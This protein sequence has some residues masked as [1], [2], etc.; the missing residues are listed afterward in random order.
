MSATRRSILAGSAAL[1]L[2]R[3]PARAQP[4][5]STLRYG[6]S[7]YPP[8]LQPWE[9]T[10]ASAGT[11]KLLIGRS[12][13]SYDRTGTLQ[14]ELATS[15]SLDDDGAWVF[16][17]RRDARFHNG[18]PVT[19]EDVRWTVEQVAAGRSTAYMRAQFQA[20]GRVETPDPYTVRLVT[21]ERL[22]TV[23]SWFANYNMAICWHGS[24]PKALV[25]CGPFRLAG[26]ERGTSVTVQASGQY[27]KPGLPRLAGITFLAY[28]DENARTAA[29]Q[30]GDLDMI[31]YVPWQ[32]MGTVEAD[33]RLRLDEVAGAAFMDV[34]FN[35]TRPPFNDP[36]VRRAV[37]HAV[38][39][40]DI[41]QSVF[42]GRGKVLEGV[43]IAAGTPFHDE[44]L[45]HGWAYDPARAKALLAEAGYPGGFRTTLLATAQYIMHKATAEVVQQHLGAVGIDAE[46]KLPDWS[47]RVSL[48]TRGQYDLAIHGVAA[49]SNDPD[50]LAVVMDTSLS[51]THGRSFGVAAP[52]TTEAFARGRA[53]FDQAK[54]VDIYRDMQRAALEEVPL[55]GLA[56][57]S[58]GFGMDRRVTGFTNLPGALSTSSGITLEQTGLG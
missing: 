3:G 26:Q 37:A 1:A 18:E 27:Y 42:F 38:R 15:W 12:L 55:V 36:R 16:R 39:R 2:L 31:E 41:V 35:G 40:E 10:G 45:A 53:E 24:D 19:A 21:R 4:R 28:P 56:W 48:G 6:L 58:Q 17:L 13:V 47:T 29:L 14:G 9:N 57:R 22:A 43:P 25:G 49:D 50:G 30:A 11:V 23:P 52:R 54:R 7:A 33:P 32:S 8:N 44:A 5:A 51:P 20:I 46:L 34:L